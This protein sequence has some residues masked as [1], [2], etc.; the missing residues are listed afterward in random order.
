MTDAV[1]QVVDTMLKPYAIGPDAMP[2]NVEV[3]T[4][5]HSLAFC[6]QNEK[7]FI[8]SCLP[9]QGLGPLIGE[10]HVYFLAYNTSGNHLAA[11]NDLY[12][13]IQRVKRE[14]GHGKV[15]ILAASLGATVFIGLME[16]YPEVYKDLNK[17]CLAVP[18]CDGTTLIGDALTNNLSVEDEMLYRDLF[19]SLLDTNIVPGASTGYIGYLISILLRILP[20]DV[21]RAVL[22]TALG[23]LTAMI[24]RCT[25]MWALC[26]S[27]YYAESCARWLNDPGTAEIKKQTDRYFRAQADAKDN[28]LSFAAKGIRFYDIVDYDITLY[29]IA[30]SWKEYNSDGTIPLYST[31]MGAT[32]GYVNTPLPAGY[33]QQNTHCSDP[34]HNHLSPDGIVD[35]STGLFPDTTWYFRWQRHEQS[36]DNDVIIKLVTQLLTN[37]TI[38]S[39]FSDPRF[40]HF[41]NGR[42][43][44]GF[45]ND[46]TRAKTIDQ[47]A[48]A[49]EDAAELQAAI[50]QAEAVMNN[51]V[52]DT[53]AYRAAQD[54]LYG[55]LVKIGFV[56]APED[57]AA[58]AAAA[59][60]LRFVSDTLYTCF[61]G[62]GFS[63]ILRPF[64]PSDFKY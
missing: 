2:L 19:P 52:V 8:Y 17:V 14:T 21:L 50:E 43:T 22:D 38:T 61:G 53:A 11:V 10:D 51:T 28:F 5:P 20:E 12:E 36:P 24:S 18:A 30:R 35:A 3:E 33:A 54:R 13:M 45:L 27:S 39:V 9:I 56:P 37:D 63:D 6:T 57:S 60:I 64:I 47:S 62:C 32:C 48:L 42:V 58:A 29:T 34:S 46:I 55:I 31:S 26:P 59:V 40:P 25:T 41:N 1:G 7:D 49:P 16:Y 4:Y 44:D 15:N 23:K